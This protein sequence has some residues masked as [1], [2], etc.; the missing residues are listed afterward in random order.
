MLS[1]TGVYRRV[2]ELMCA[3]AAVWLLLGCR[4]SETLDSRWKGVPQD[5][6]GTA[7]KLDL[8]CLQEEAFRVDWFELQSGKISDAVEALEGT[9]ILKL[10]SLQALSMI[11]DPGPRPLVGT[12][13]LVR[14]FACLVDGEPFLDPVDAKMT[15]D[16]LWID[17]ATTPQDS[18]VK[19]PVVVYLPKTPT[20]EVLSLQT[21][22]PQRSSTTKSGS[23]VEAR[24]AFRQSH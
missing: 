20:S 23:G 7:G 14:S 3:L 19:R 15:G 12:P 1:R 22:D 8:R 16:C 21:Y 5:W 18:V 9:W 11:A 13:Y 17:V 2:V 10:D 6:L 4:R 24:Q